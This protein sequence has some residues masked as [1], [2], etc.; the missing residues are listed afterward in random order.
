[1]VW[2][3]LVWIK[4]SRFGWQDQCFLTFCGFVHPWYRLLHFHSPYCE[5]MA[6]VTI[7]IIHRV[8]SVKPRYL[9]YFIHS[10]LSAMQQIGNDPQMW[11]DDTLSFAK[12]FFSFRQ[13]RRYFKRKKVAFYLLVELFRLM[14][15]GNFT[16]C[17]NIRAVAWKVARTCSENAVFLL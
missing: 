14:T 10:M 11:F 7:I 17:T 8:F 5:C 15:G 6:D 9:L 16:V 13:H 1:M 2:L 12:C 4:Y 3:V